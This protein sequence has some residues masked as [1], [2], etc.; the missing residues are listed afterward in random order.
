MKS[1]RLVLGVVLASG[2]VLAADETCTPKYEVGLNYSWLHVNS[3]NKLGASDR[4]QAF[5]IAV[6]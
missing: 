1:L 4:T 5:A 6:R 3:A 2:V